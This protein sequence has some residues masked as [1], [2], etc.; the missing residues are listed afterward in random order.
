MSLTRQGVEQWRDA[1][2]LA[3]Y[4][5]THVN[6][7][8]DLALRGLDTE[9]VIRAL[10][11]MQ[12]QLAAPVPAIYFKTADDV[13]AVCEALDAERYVLY[14]DHAA[15]LEARDK[16]IRELTAGYPY[17]DPVADA[18]AW[19][20]TA[21]DWKKQAEA[22]EARVRELEG[23][24]RWLDEQHR[25]PHNMAEAFIVERIRAALSTGEGEE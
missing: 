19:E 15:A 2:T 14:T 3:D 7:L 24:L 1:L 16:R 21:N 10:E 12:G 9:P 8:C 6:E 17:S 11:K 18:Y 20:A 13:D 23:A 22:A 25:D 5:P 4:D